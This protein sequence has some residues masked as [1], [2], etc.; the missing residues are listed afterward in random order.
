MIDVIED[1]E[2]SPADLEDAANS[3]TLAP[4]VDETKAKLLNDGASEAAIKSADA[5]ASRGEGDEVA[6]VNAKQEIR[7]KVSVWDH[8]EPTS[9][10]S[11]CFDMLL[12]LVWHPE[13]QVRIFSGRIHL[14]RLRRMAITLGPPAST[15]L[16]MAIAWQGRL[17]HRLE[18]MKTTPR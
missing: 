6:A 14:P 9:D 4:V 15:K 10:S 11:P 5:I 8:I 16:Q 7:A 17:S 12:V 2:T 13:N 1:D 18:R 3:R